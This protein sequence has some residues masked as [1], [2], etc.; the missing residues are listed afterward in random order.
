[1]IESDWQAL[2][3]RE[4]ADSALRLQYSD[5]LE[6]Q[7]LLNE[8]EVQ[9]WLARAGKHPNPTGIDWEW[10]QEG[11]ID[12]RHVA[13]RVLPRTLFAHLSG[14]RVAYRSYGSRREAERDLIG[15]WSRLKQTGGSLH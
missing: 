12:P 2:L 1:M 5:W 9:R 3:D 6:E 15:A 11:A 10:W 4:P 13:H 7:G 14:G 8:A